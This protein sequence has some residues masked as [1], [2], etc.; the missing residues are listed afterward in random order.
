MGVRHRRNNSP[1]A[2]AAPIAGVWGDVSVTISF[3]AKLGLP[4][5]LTTKNF[6]K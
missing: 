3:C 4:L 1:Y 2:K 6:S 5:G